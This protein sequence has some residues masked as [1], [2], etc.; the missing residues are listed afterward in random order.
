MKRNQLLSAVGI[1]LF[2]T[3]SLVA[4][5]QSKP[6]TLAGVELQKL[7]NGTQPQYEAGRKQKAAWHKQQNDSVPL[8]V[9]Q[10]LTG[11]NTG[12]FYV[13]R[14]GQHWTTLDK[15]SV[16]DEADEAE[17]QKLMG[18][19]VESMTLR[20]YDFMPKVSNASGDMMPSKF[21][22]LHI[23][24]VRYA[25]ES[26]FHSAMSRIHDASEKT[27]WPLNYEWYELESGGPSGLFVLAIPHKNWADFEDNPNVKP[28]R[29]MLKEAFGQAEADS[30]VERINQ[31]VEKETSEILQFRPDL[32]YLPSK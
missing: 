4:Q 32:S 11:D 18:A 30:I 2:A 5:D 1:L 16:S 14:F 28:F 13:G 20:Y 17:Y 6:G 7:K 15:P 3:C 25:K 24:Q 26:D 12:A 19:Y 22:D 9:W 31:S 27:K 29:D 8:F 21:T 23:F 10:I